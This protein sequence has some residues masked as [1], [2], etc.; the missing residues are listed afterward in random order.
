[1]VLLALAPAPAEA[2]PP[3][4]VG[5]WQRPAAEVG[6]LPA[7]PPTQP[8]PA[9]PLVA[10]PDGGLYVANDPSGPSAVSALRF[11]DPPAAAA[12]VVLPVAENPV[13]PLGALL[14]ACPAAGPWAS[15]ANGAWGARAVADCG[16]GVQGAFGDGLT[17]VTFDL[18]DLAPFRTPQGIEM[19]IVPGPDEASA[20]AVAFDRPGADTAIFRG[21]AG[22]P[23]APVPQASTGPAPGADGGAA[24]VAFPVP[25][26][27][28]GDEVLALPATP[29]DATPEAGAALSPRVRAAP[30]SIGTHGAPRAVLTAL[31]I[32]L[33][34]VAWVTSGGLGTTR[35]RPS[36]QEAQS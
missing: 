18:G 29:T 20:Y 27:G 13:I 35:R 6:G 19:V 3:I 31:L 4:A 30:I 23:P 32:A 2:A 22:A 34:C 9:P 24:P 33:A 15:A 21:D 36:P 11:E 7:A 16:R 14:F 1:L 8:P 12:T 26:P 17:T 10:V 5:W 28:P 25:I